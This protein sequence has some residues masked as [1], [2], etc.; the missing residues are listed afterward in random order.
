MVSCK[1]M[2]HL[3]KFQLL[4]L[5][6]LTLKWCITKNMQEWNAEQNQE[7]WEISQEL[8]RVRGEE[9]GSTTTAEAPVALCIWGHC[10]SGCAGERRVGR[11]QPDPKHL[12]LRHQ[13]TAFHS[14]SCPAAAAALALPK[15]WNQ[16]CSNSLEKEPHFSHGHAEPQH[17]CSKHPCE[18]VCLWGLEHPWAGCAQERRRGHLVVFSP[19]TT[20]VPLLSLGMLWHVREQAT[21]F[22]FTWR[23]L[24]HSFSS[25]FLTLEGWSCVPHSP[26]A[27]GSF[28]RMSLP[29]PT[30][31]LR[32]ARV[33]SHLNWQQ[34]SI[35]AHYCSPFLKI[36]RRRGFTKDLCNYSHHLVPL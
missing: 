21:A 19:P 16:S 30:D 7:R 29:R 11:L 8:M 15:S 23:G 20:E 36:P 35:F 28:G 6:S 32:R 4:S 13:G 25:S 26:W 2:Q 5:L 1:I 34:L 22:L 27:K 12:P 33:T 18:A 9:K 17:L 14:P 3:F 10:R 24:A 31:R